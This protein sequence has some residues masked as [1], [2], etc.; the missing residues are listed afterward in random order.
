MISDKIGIDDIDC[1]IMDL[2]QK[3]PTLTHTEIAGHVNRS[4]PTIGMRIKRL[5]R[6][7]ILKYQAGVNIKA[8]E[9][10]FARAEV[11]TKNPSKLFDIVKNCPFM[12]T[13]FRLSG[14]TNISILIAGSTLK[15]LDHVVNYHLRSNPEIIEVHMDIIE[16]VVDDLVLPIDL[17]FD[18]SKI[19]LKRSCC[20]ACEN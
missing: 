19:D 20:G 8:A 7:G 9:L 16:N 11:R 14:N 12:L 13:A 10:H 1:K 6:I 17:S 2:I 5:E 4:Q 18:Y 3:E 15:D